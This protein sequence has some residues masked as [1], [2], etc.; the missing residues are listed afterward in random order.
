MDDNNNTQPIVDDQTP[1]VPV[2]D[3]A[4]TVPADD[5]TPVEEPVVSDTPVPT[6]IEGAEE[7][8]EETESFEDTPENVSKDT[9]VSEDL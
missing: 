9:P 3:Q 8:T 5:Q 6:P 1:I 4:A 7:D 2:D